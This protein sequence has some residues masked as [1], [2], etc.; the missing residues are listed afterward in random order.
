V[1]TPLVSVVTERVACVPAFVTVTVAPGRTLLDP[2]TTEPLIWPVRPCP[3]ALDA[4]PNTTATEATHCCTE[5]RIVPSPPLARERHGPTAA[6]TLRTQAARDGPGTGSAGAGDGDA[7]RAG[8]TAA[9][10]LRIQRN[11]V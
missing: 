7:M 6:R 1:K 8:L 9:G 5:A 11:G 4:T 10:A 3:Y 2:S